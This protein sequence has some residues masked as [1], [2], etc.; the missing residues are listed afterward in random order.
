MSEHVF[1]DI[2][3]H[4][5]RH[6][7]NDQPLLRR[8]VEQTVHRFL[9]SRCAQTKGVFLHAIGGTE[10]HVHLAL[11]V[12]PFVGIS[13]LVGDLKGAS[14][15]EVNRHKRFKAL[16]W[17]RGFSVVSFG[18]KNLPFVVEYIANQ[19]EHHASGS[20]SK[21]TFGDASVK[22]PGKTRSSPNPILRQ[23]SFRKRSKKGTAYDRL[24]RTAG[25]EI[26]AR[27][28]QKHNEPP[29]NG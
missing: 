27:K 29:E 1:H 3:L 19:K 6:T 24:E 17:Q 12:E 5:T 10:T 8:D 9:R 15:R 14:S 21:R 18:R 20:L 2:C 26:P 23:S 11:S 22:K 4:I 16:S 7:R 13:H 28:R 25:E